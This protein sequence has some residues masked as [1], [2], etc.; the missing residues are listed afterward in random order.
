MFP[1]CLRR[2]NKHEKLKVQILATLLEHFQMGMSS[3]HGPRGGPPLENKR[4]S[5]LRRAVLSDP[6][7]VSQL[8]MYDLVLTLEYPLH[9]IGLIIKHKSL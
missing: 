9:G 7:T 2:H 3:A 8:K 5:S 4:Q 6:K 1:L